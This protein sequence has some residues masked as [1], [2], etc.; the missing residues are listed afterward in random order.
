VTGRVLILEDNY[1]LAMDM[2]GCAT[3]LGMS[4]ILTKDPAE[5]IRLARE[6]PF[7]AALLDVNLGGAFEGL[8]VARTIF[9]LG[10]T[11]VVIVTGYDGADLARRMDGFESVPVVFKPIRKE[12]I[13]ELL[14]SFS[15]AG[16]RATA[17]GRANSSA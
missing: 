5:A 6:R 13:C 16:A 11:P 4:A 12:L 10:H 9:S 15:Q 8:E 1:L 14:K 3:E 7:A 17:V 2:K